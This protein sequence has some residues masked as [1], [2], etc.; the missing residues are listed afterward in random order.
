VDGA[1]AYA[2]SDRAR[3]PLSDMELGQPTAGRP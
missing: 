3:Q 2:R 1:L